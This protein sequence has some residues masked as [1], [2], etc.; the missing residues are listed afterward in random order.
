MTMKYNQAATLAKDLRDFA[1]FIDAHGVELP[2]SFYGTDGVVNMTLY[3]DSKESLAKA[4]R[5]LAKGGMVNKTFTNYA[6]SM[7]RKFGSSITV[8]YW[9]ER[10]NACVAKVVGQEVKPVTKTVETG[11]YTTVDIV[12]WECDPILS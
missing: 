8:E 2:N 4:V 7:K 9:T 1:D 6:A 10:T 11:E 5:A 3:V 12:E